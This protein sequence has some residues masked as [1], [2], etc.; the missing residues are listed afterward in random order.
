MADIYE[1]RRESL[2]EYLKYMHLQPNQV[3]MAVAIDG[4]TAGI[5]FF[6]DPTVFGQFFDKLMRAY[7]AEVVLENRIVTMVPDKQALE[8]LLHRV[9]ASQWDEY[10]AV[11]SGKELRTR[12]GR[13]NGSALDVD[14]RL[15]HMAVLRGHGRTRH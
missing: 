1:S 5:E 2:D 13:L 12:M 4:K 11:G 3:G 9:A 7:A 14:G 10:P 8:D 15:L 6:E